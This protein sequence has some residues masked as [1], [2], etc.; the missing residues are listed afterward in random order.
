MLQKFKCCDAAKPKM[1]GKGKK[2]LTIR[3]SCLKPRPG[4]PI[5]SAIFNKYPCNHGI[6]AEMTHQ[7]R[8]PR[9]I[10]DQGRIGSIAPPAQI[11]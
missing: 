9:P 3:H 11:I 1:H 10:P 4:T 7:E 8:G 2:R 6:V 5:L